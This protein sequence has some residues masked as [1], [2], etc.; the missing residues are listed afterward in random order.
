MANTKSS[1]KRIL[2]NKLR[3]KLNT[4][5][6]SKL[7]TYIKKTKLAIK[8]K[9][10]KLAIKYYCITQSLLDKYSTKNIIHI[11]KSSRYKSFLLKLIN[12]L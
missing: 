8:D 12:N 1:K 3:N 9:D 6:K 10:Q 2:I 7:K 11:N 4:S 5:K